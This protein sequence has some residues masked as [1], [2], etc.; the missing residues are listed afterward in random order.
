MSCSC[1]SKSKACAIKQIENKAARQ[2]NATPV[3]MLD[4]LDAFITQL[5][6]I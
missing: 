4:L 1:T 5:S 2:S 6:V 3:I